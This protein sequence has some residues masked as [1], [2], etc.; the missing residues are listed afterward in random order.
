MAQRD[1]MVDLDRLVDL[2]HR[3]LT[4]AM[5]RAAFRSTRVT[6]RQ[7]AW[8]LYALVRF[9]VAV[10]LHAPKALSHA[11]AEAQ[12]DPA[13]VYPA[14]PATPEAFFQRCRDLRPAFFAEVFRRFTAAMLAAVPPR[15]AA[16]VAPV[17]D[18]FAAL[19]VVDGSRLAAIARRLK[20]L[21][22]ERAVVL[23]GCLLAVYDLSYGLCRPGRRRQ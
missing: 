1:R 19:V 10:V 16:E 5:C 12:D 18:R 6:E 2:L 9:W 8:T 15:Y 4:A 21:W 7:R 3:H 22:N 23:P 20:L 17:R 13:S 11:L 14:V